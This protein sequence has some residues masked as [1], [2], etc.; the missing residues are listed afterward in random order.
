MVIDFFKY[1]TGNKG[2][3]WMNSIPIRTC[4]HYN[5]WLV[6]FKV[7]FFK[8]N[9]FVCSDCGEVLQGK[10]LKGHENKLGLSNV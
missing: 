8:R 2:I 7:L 10:A 1:K 9:A 5:G 6:E 4:G 3:G